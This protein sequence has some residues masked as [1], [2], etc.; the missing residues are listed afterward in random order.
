MN[1]KRNMGRLDQMVR[2]VVGLASIYFGFI[3]STL[4][5]E[6]VIAICLGTFGI[7]NLLSVV[8]RYCPLYVMA[9]ISTSTD[10]HA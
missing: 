4:I 8:M 9:G 2:I 6:P 7:L 10:R 5:A 1:I 3:D